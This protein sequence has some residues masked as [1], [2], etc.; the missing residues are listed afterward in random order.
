M[1]YATFAITILGITMY[2]EIQKFFKG[3]IA[4][5]EVTLDT[6]S[7]DASLFEIKPT[8]VVFPKDSTDIQNLVKWSTE[9]KNKYPTLSLT[10][11]AAGTCMS[12]GPLN[13]SIII[14]TT[15]YM[16]KIISVQK[17]QPETIKLKWDGKTEVITTGL[18]RVEPGCFYR[19][20]EM[21]TLK[22]DLLLPC[23][24]ASKSLNAIGG[25]V[26]NNSAGELT[27]RYGKTEDYVAELKV[28][29]SDGHE[30]VIRPLTRRE[31]YVKIT[32]ATLEGKVYKQLF[33]LIKDHESL[34]Q[35]AKPTVSKNSAGYNLWNILQRGKVDP[36]NPS[37]SDEDVFDLT[38]LFI[39]SQ[40]T[41]GIVTEVTFRLVD[42]IKMSKLLVVF[43]DDLSQLGSAVKE[44]LPTNPISIESYDDKTFGLAI[45]FFPDLLRVKGLWDMFTFSVSFIPEFFMVVFGGVP[46]MVLLVEYA[47]STEKEIDL[48]CKNTQKK[49][50]HFGFKTRVTRSPREAEKYWT[51]RR[52]SFALLRKHVQGKRT[53]PFI[54]DIIVRPEFLPEFLPKINALIESYPEL[55][56]TIAG[57]AANGNFHIIPLVDPHDPKLADIVIELSQKVYD[58]VLSYHGSIDAEHND[59]IIRTPFLEKMYGTEV[60]ALFSDVKKLF[61]PL[62]IF[63]PKKKVGGTLA[64][65]RANL[66]HPDKHANIH[67]S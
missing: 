51:M 36:T 16:N 43:M 46:K 42:K 53:A 54:D 35:G 52:D 19:D 30:Y 48:A 65:I 40:G 31:L 56:Y 32:E 61:D 50:A 4:H 22:Q 2:E 49:I 7:R 67:N 44:L 41:L 66:V 37:E 23:Y 29:L 59:G 64:D 24:T 27:L 57:H 33:D 21:E 20:F 39:G 10:A 58:L 45:K 38:Q 13:D 25:M 14:D 9:N 62:V 28:I 17:S 63:N 34:I 18:A 26:G 6:Y 8:L 47:G 5:D 60:Y 15:K 11:R 3:D 1:D 12:G 55:T